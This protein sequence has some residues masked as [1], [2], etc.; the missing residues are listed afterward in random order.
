MTSSTESA[1]P[2]RHPTGV[3]AKLRSYQFN[4]SQKILH[5][6]IRPTILG[7][8]QLKAELAADDEVC[9]VMPY[10]STADLLVVDR[11]TQLFELPRPLAPLNE[12]E[13]RAFF[14]L[15]HPEG[16]I[17]RKTQRGQSERLLRIMEQTR[18]DLEQSLANTATGTDATANVLPLQPG[19]PTKIVPV[20]LFW[21]HQPDRE[22]SI[23]KLLLSENWTVTSRFKRLMSSIVHRQ[24]ILVRFG[25]PIDL[26]ELVSSEP[27]PAKQTRK[28][29][30]ILRT[31]FTHQKQA[32]IGPDLSHRRNL[33]GVMLEADEVKDAIS[34]EAQANGKTVAAIESKAL[35]Y[36]NEIASDQSYRVIRFFHI[37]L[38]WLWNN[39]YEGID[40]NRVEVAQDLART[41]EIVYIPCHRSH[42]DYLLLSYVLYHNGL[43][44][45]HIAAGKNLNLPIAGP[46]LRRAGA[47]FMRRSFKDDALYKAVFDEYLH[48]M[49][50]RGYSVEY[51]IEG[52]RSRTG[53]TL[54]PRTGML[55]MTLRSFQRDASKPIAFLPVYFGYERVIEAPTYVGELTGKTKKEE[56]IF[57]MFGIFRS[58]T[59]PFGRVAVNFGE[60]VIL[61]QFLDQSWPNWRDE[62][63]QDEFSRA[64]VELADQLANNINGAAAITP[65]NLLATSILATPKQI[66]PRERLERQVSLLQKLAQKAPPSPHITVPDQSAK[67]L[68]DQAIEV[69]QL[70]STDTE[71]GVIV[72]ADQT[73]AVL[74]TYY[75][76]NSLHV[77]ALASLLARFIKFGKLV[78]S[79][80]LISHC[81]VLQPYLEAELMWRWGDNLTATIQHTLNTMVELE[82][83]VQEGDV[84]K[85]PAPTS[86]AS[87]NLNDLA[88]VIEPMLERFH[89]VCTLLKHD[90]AQ[91]QDQLESTAS[92]IARQL[93]TIYGLSAPE[94]FDKKLFNRFLATLTTEG[95]LSADLTLL[96]EAKFE[97]LAYVIQTVLDSDV[98]YNLLQAVHKHQTDLP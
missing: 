47:F 1:K 25:Q 74:L 52:G 53:R 67:A 16:L 17:G 29:L 80:Q 55:S 39:L 6:W 21:G 60:P 84:L 64:C 88:E 19:K 81:Q 96:A 71:F 72:Q 70:E 66:I 54:V 28:L 30:R 18:W 93:S 87:A 12:R 58:F 9:Y 98:S 42:I 24:H 77:Y 11:A 22:N 79:K 86:D 43:T 41:H 85:I 63:D 26:T 13:N 7:T 3:L 45:P 34:K 50:T 27:D 8:E 20:S 65:S 91:S 73:E 44:P 40:I 69:A 15:G 76:N 46:L 89:I 32:I 35:K 36:A 31:H 78:Q 83:I 68:V 56:S 10:Q 59:K 75:Q 48:Q 49:F 23:F 95:C 90:T 97:R 51:F 82:V 4:L 57:D 5:S 37:L 94:F 62:R 33:I 38:T 14:F 92:G 61:D 2:P